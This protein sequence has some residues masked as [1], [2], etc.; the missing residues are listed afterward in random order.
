MDKA[1]DQDL[2]YRLQT[3]VGVKKLNS[4][5]VSFDSQTFDVEN[6]DSEVGNWKNAAENRRLIFAAGGFDMTV[7]VASMKFGSD[8][9]IE[10]VDN[11]VEV[12]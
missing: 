4:E 12:L 1:C 6:F 9:A 10:V 2:G 7:V 3:M 5:A 11:S 8:F